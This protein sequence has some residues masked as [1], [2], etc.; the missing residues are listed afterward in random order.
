MCTLGEDTSISRLEMLP[1]PAPL[2]PRSG[3]WPDE[4]REL[5]AVMAQAVQALEEAGMTVQDL[6]N[7]LPAAGEE[8]MRQ[9][10]GDALSRR[11]AA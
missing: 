2:S 11:P 4:D 1:M 6:L 8:V 9:I 7:E 5:E 10:Y 3:T